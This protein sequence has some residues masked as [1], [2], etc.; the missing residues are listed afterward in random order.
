MW[1]TSLEDSRSPRREEPKLRHEMKKMQ[2]CSMTTNLK[3]FTISLVWTRNF[4]VLRFLSSGVSLNCHSLSLC[5]V[6]CCVNG[7]PMITCQAVV[8][9]SE[10]CTMYYKSNCPLM[11]SCIGYVLIRFKR[12]SGCVRATRS[13]HKKVPRVY[14]LHLGLVC[15][16]ILLHLLLRVKTPS[17][18]NS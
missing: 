3:K 5:K 11:I 16:F 9:L 15:F 10:W 8:P 17:L 4:S 12:L 18:T 7:P 14:F 1:Y 13:P 6:K 2:M